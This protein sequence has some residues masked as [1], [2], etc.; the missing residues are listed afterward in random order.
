[1]IKLSL[2]MTDPVEAHERYQKEIADYKEKL[3]KEY[4]GK[5]ADL[6]A[7]I[8]KQRKELVATKKGFKTISEKRRQQSCQIR[9][10]NNRIAQQ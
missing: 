3:R 7:Q 8:E 9:A 4:E 6:E 10:L 2:F 1:M 5:M